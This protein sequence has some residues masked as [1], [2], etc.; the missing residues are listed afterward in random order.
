[1]KTSQHLP[2]LA[3]LL[4]PPTF[5]ADISGFMTPRDMLRNEANSN[6][7]LRNTRNTD[8]TVY[9]LYVRQYAYLSPGQ[10]CDSATPIYT[11]NITTGAVVSPTDIKAGKSVAIGSNYLY[12]MILQAIYYEYL[13]IPSPPGCAL[14]G[15]T[16][17]SDSALFN[18]CIYLGAFTSSANSSTYTSN[19]P[20]SNEAAS[21]VGY[22]YNLVTNYINLGP[23]TCN[24][25]TLSCKVTNPQT[26]SFS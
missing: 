20:P 10:S 26:Q 17:G 16:W 19:V 18:W 7:N 1:M 13:N 8:I 6:I 12:N 9:G 4:L 11:G 14:P 24:D 2:L 25:Q 3:L 5:A 23:I 15:C 22:N 21:G